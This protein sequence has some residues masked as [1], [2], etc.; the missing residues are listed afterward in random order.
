[1]SAHCGVDK[2]V[3][4]ASKI[5]YKNLLFYKKPPASKRAVSKT[6]FA[7]T[8]IELLTIILILGV[9]TSVAVP[10]YLDYGTEAR[11]AADEASMGA[12]RTALN[13]TFAK[14]RVGDAPNSQWILLVTDVKNAMENGE[15]P[16][17]IEE[18]SGQEKLRDRR[19]NTYTFTPETATASA[20][21]TL[22]SGGGG[23][24]G[25]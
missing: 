6:A 21:L 12:I 11:K 13:M 3:G 15:L 4:S 25:S 5:K 14:H 24:G 17:G 18:I 2:R 9:L 8:L 23:G 22:D 19:G 10:A 7:F 16:E 20:F 1:M